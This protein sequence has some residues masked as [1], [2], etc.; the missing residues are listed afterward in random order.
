MLQFLVQMAYVPLLSPIYSLSE[1]HQHSILQCL[2]N[3]PLQ[4]GFAFIRFEAEKDADNAKK[5]LHGRDMGGLNINI[6]KL[7]FL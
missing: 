4:N 5:E 7:P 3:I 6:G 2:T 1:R